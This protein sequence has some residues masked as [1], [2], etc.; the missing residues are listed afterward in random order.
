[1]QLLGERS[2][3]QLIYSNLSNEIQVS[4]DTIRRWIDLLTRLHYGFLVR[5]WFRNVRQGSAKRAEVVPTGFE[6]RDR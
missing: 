1:M 6:R 4:V 3:Q 5:P 2:A